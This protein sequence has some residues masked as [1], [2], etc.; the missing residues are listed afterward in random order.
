MLQAF[1]LKNTELLVDNM[2]N[3]TS[4]SIYFSGLAVLMSADI[5]Q[6]L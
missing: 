1:A 3:I 2:L 4:N 6:N 5:A